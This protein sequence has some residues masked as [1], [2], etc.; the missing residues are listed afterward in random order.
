MHMKLFSFCR[1]SF[2]FLSLSALPL[3]LHA[4]AHAQT[5]TDDHM[6]FS[7]E[8]GFTSSYETDSVRFFRD[9]TTL[10][11]IGYVEHTNGEYRK[12]HLT[13]L[14]FHGT[15]EYQALAT[16]A[17]WDNFSADR[18]CRGTIGTITVTVWDSAALRI[19]GTFSFDCESRTTTGEILEYRVRN[20]EFRAVE[21]QKLELQ[22]LPEEQITIRPNDTATYR[23]TVKDPTGAL[24]EGAEVHVDDSVQGREDFSVGTTN[25]SGEVE[26]EVIARPGL[27]TG[28][29]ALRFRATHDD[30]EESDEVERK[31]RVDST[32]QIWRQLCNGLP[33]LEFDVGN[34]NAWEDAGLSSIQYNGTVTINGFMKFDGSMRI[35]TTVGAER[36]EANG[37]LYIPG[38]SLPGGSTGEWVLFNGNE[39]F[40]PRCGVLTAPLNY[41]VGNGLTELAGFKVKIDEF[42]FIGGVNSTGV[43]VK[44]TIEVPDFTSICQPAATEPYNDTVKFSIG[45]SITTEG[46][47]GFST[48]IQQLGIVPRFC[49]SELTVAYASARDSL[50]VTAAIKTPLLDAKAGIGWIAGALNRL[51]LR[52]DA[53]TPIPIGT[54]PLG[55]KGG[56]GEVR[57]LSVPPF[58]FSLGGTLATVGNPNF[59]EI[60]IDGGY[61]APSKLNLSGALRMF[62]PPGSDKWQVLGSIAG[63]LDL[64]TSMGLSGSFQAGNLGG[65]DYAV[66]GSAALQYVWSPTEDVTGTVRGDLRIPTLPADWPFDWVNSLLGLP[67]TLT[68][69]DA[70]LRNGKITANLDMTGLPS[71]ADQLGRL[72]VRIDMNRE[73]GDE[74][75]IEMGEGTVPLNATRR[76]GTPVSGISSIPGLQPSRPLLSDVDRKGPLPS[77]ATVFDTVVVDSPVL[78]L[79]ARISSD[80]TAPTSRMIGPDGTVYTDGST[81]PV[82]LSMTP[83][84]SKAFWTVSNPTEG[85]WIVAVDDPTAGDSIDFYVVLPSRPFA[86][87]AAREGEEIVVEW[88]GS[89]APEGSRVDLHLDTDAEGY[90][91]F[92]IGSADESAGTFRYTITD[93]LPGCAYHVHAARYSP[94]DMVTAYAPEAVEN[95]KDYLLAPTGIEAFPEPAGRTLVTW[96]KSTD[97]TV[98][99]YVLRGIDATGKDSAWA[100]LYPSQES[101]VITLP[102]GNQE[103]YMIA[104]D[105]EGR[106]GCPGSATMTTVGVEDRSVSEGTR[107]VLSGL[108]CYPNPAGSGTAIRFRLAESESISLELY[109]PSGE[110]V[111]RRDLRRLMPGEQTIHLE[112]GSLP[113]GSYTLL[114]R[115]DRGGVTDRLTVVR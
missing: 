94:G 114:L 15:G 88:D 12:M 16:T 1:S 5:P 19:E 87:T 96:T 24:L 56:R 4:T 29:Y 101:V 36:M 84:G 37:R 38:T 57:G 72:Y 60:D 110:R 10:D 43:S 7:V 100:L 81:P 73:Y 83:D 78:R 47:V 52:V 62:K 34:G 79:I 115:G 75:F 98:A 2:L 80:G 91:G 99:G 76:T 68:S 20:G 31:A 63:T 13:L 82:F 18:L 111:Y 90:D 42:N 49:L 113:S 70:G 65:S 102:Q 105:E 58:A 67:Y 74:G 86:V 103:L 93:S 108:S 104:F 40:T 112:T 41:V 106:Q 25:A 55:L 71:P 35:D 45:F 27:D 11:L 53:A 51:L 17:R 66:N 48:S 77:A 69:V 9:G 109:G 107:G 95:P 54:L 64:G 26:Y 23:L 59:L 50:D 8:A 28:T 46:A 22:V 14:N 44:A 61:E 32:L 92:L 89:G 30:F 21:T 3:L 39:N 85:E 97:P 33:V 6:S